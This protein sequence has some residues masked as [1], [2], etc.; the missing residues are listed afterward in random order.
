MA[1]KESE[2]QGRLIEKLKTMF[3][4]CLVLKNDPNYKQGIPDLA[5]FY[6]NHWAMLECKKNAA[7]KARPNQEYYISMLNDMSYAAFIYPE[8]EEAILDALQ[9]TFEA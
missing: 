5:I 6:K 1:M 8:N 3:P 9:Q 2:F 4:G 7:A